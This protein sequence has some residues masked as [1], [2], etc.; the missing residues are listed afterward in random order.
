[1]YAGGTFK[2]DDKSQ[3]KGNILE[4]NVRCDQFQVKL[5]SSKKS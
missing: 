4:Q 2:G 5:F 3:L 1:M